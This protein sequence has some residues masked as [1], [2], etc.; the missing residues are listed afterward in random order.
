M[1]TN[2]F[3]IILGL[4]SNTSSSNTYTFPTKAYNNPSFTYLISC[5]QG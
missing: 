2:S 3:Q 1:H 4:G 5:S